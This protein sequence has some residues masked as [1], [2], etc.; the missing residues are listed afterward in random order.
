METVYEIVDKSVPPAECR[1]AGN[2][3]EDQYSFGDIDGVVPQL[4]QSMKNHR[5]VLKIGIYCK[6]VLTNKYLFEGAYIILFIED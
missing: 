6:F 4:K 5:V 1:M 2:Y 3:E